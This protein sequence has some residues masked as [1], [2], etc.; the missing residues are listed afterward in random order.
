[1]DIPLL[2]DINKRIASDYNVLITEGDNAGV[3]LR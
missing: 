3:A 1:M 2:S